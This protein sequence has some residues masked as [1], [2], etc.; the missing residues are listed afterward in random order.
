MKRNEPTAVGGVMPAYFEALGIQD[1]VNE[2]IL[3]L[4]W[5]EQMGQVISK[6]TTHLEVKNRV[7]YVSISS[8]P[9]RGNLL[10]K[11]EQLVR[12]LNDSVGTQ[13]IDDIVFR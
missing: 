3:M 6:K 12:L 13:V 9:L 11:R 10:L 5:N 1:K 7:L 2:A 4:A 8:A